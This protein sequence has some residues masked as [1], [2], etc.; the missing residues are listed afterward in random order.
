[1]PGKKGPERPL[2][3]AAF[4]EYFRIDVPG[5]S[6]TKNTLDVGHKVRYY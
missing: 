5:Y 4:W 3:F 2:P 6:V 1:M